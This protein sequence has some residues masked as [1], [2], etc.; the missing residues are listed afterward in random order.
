VVVVSRVYTKKNRYDRELVLVN[1]ATGRR[2]VLTCERKGVA[3]P[4]WSPLGNRLAF[5]AVAG[6]GKKA[7]HQV[8]VL[9]RN[10]GDA[11]RGTDA[12]EPADKARQPRPAGGTCRQ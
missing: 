9:P 8:L 10:G 5:L 4:R 11:R 3:H 2:R 12:P 1:I 6:A 7:H